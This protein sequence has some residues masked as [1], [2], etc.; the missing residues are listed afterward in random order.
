MI[1]NAGLVIIIRNIVMK[2]RKIVYT[3]NRPRA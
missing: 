1:L 2:I 3:D